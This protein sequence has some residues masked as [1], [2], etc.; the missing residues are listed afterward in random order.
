M[1]SG[2]IWRGKKG[3]KAPRDLRDG[4]MKEGA[5]R[6]EQNTMHVCKISDVAAKRAKKSSGRG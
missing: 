3:W 4:E 2:A 5:R 6:S 1:Q